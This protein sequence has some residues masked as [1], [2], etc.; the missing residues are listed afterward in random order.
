VVRAGLSAHPVAGKDA[1]V[2]AELTG[3]E[4]HRHSRRG[5]H[6]VGAEPQHPHAA[7]LQGP[8]QAV[9]VAVPAAHLG[10]VGVAQREEPVQRLAVELGREA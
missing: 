7:Q 9:R 1:R 8:A 2:D 4:S 10:Q 6:V 5:G 3:Q